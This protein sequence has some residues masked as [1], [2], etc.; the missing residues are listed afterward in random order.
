[1]K[2]LFGFIAIIIISSLFYFFAGTK[3]DSLTEQTVM[4]KIQ[5]ELH[6][7]KIKIPA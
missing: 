5:E 4:E 1:M 7:K 6:R 3:N 2:I